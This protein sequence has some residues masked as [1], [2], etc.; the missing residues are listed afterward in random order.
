MKDTLL[1]T[2]K[3]EQGNLTFFFSLGIIFFFNFLDGI[4]TSVDFVRDEVN[5]IVAAYNSSHCVIF[6][7]E[8]GKPVIRLES[9]QV[10]QFV[11]F[12]LRWIKMNGHFFR[13]RLEGLLI[14]QFTASFHTQCCQLR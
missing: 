6:D 12:L 3:S 14:N 5:Q 1:N 4:P 10:I 7:T 2:F 13:S 11:S 8:T 9:T